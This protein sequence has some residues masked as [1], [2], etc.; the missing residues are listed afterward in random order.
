MIFTDHYNEPRS[1][2]MIEIL[3][4]DESGYK[5]WKPRSCLDHFYLIKNIYYFIVTL[6]KVVNQSFYYA[7]ICIE[8]WYAKQFE[9][10]YNNCIMN[11]A[12]Q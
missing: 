11:D 7:G 6:L 9:C 2:S 8:L 4:S 3:M 12:I 10:L 5:K 1:V